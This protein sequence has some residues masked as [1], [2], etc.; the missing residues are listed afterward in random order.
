[1]RAVEGGAEPKKNSR[2]FLETYD[3]GKGRT[4][5]SILADATAT[6]LKG[7]NADK[8]LSAN[9]AAFRAGISDAEK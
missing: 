4:G 7:F 3:D 5:R 1:L 6:K 2:E 8:S 9:A